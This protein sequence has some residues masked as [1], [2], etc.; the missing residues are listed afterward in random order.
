MPSTE[1]SEK[2]LRFFKKGLWSLLNSMR[3]FYAMMVTPSVILLQVNEVLKCFSSLFNGNI[4]DLI[5]NYI[6]S[7]FEM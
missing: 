3:K 6:L 2:M 4:S 1:I 5:F 7:Y